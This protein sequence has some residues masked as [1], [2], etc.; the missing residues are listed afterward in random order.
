MKSFFKKNDLLYSLNCKIKSYGTK[1]LYRRIVAHY[2]TKDI[3]PA[4]NHKIRD[5][6]NVFYFGGDEH[7][8]KSGFLQGLSHVFNVRYFTQSDGAYGA[9]SRSDKNCK[10]LNSERLLHILAELELQGF[11]PDLILMQT[12]GW[13]ID[14]DILRK[15]KNKYQCLIVNIGMD[16]RHSY[17]IQNDWSEGTYGLIPVLDLV[18]T[19][20]PECALWFKKE[21]VNAVYFPEASHPD[22]YFPIK[23]IDK[24]YDVG[25]IGAKYGVREN[26]VNRLMQEGVDVKCYGNGWPSGRLPLK[27]TNLFFNQCRIVLG[28]GTIGH[29]EDFYALKLRDFDATMS[30]AV[31]LTHNNP[32]L[33][34]LFNVGDEVFL[35]ENEEEFVI[36]CKELLSL[37][38]FQLEK[39]SER[40]AEHS[41]LM[42]SYENRFF[43]LKNYLSKGGELSFINNINIHL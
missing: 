6:E 11:V 33:H 21:G 17:T 23:N 8:D 34:S 35:A 42:H 19:S 25:F 39:I 13:R 26:I 29:T 27:D 15:I 7:Q 10:Q 5:V 43:I 3:I 2:S 14:V 30:G 41:K 9:Y 24:L 18:L 20:A 16:D 38:D 36:K 12:W 1:K 28:V 40:T 32:D 31:Y 4:T 37:S 22:F